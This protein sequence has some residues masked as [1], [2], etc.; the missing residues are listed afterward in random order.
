MVKLS[1][2]AQ[3]IKGSPIRKM[4]NMAN[5]M[6]DVVS[7]AL[8]EPDF[9]T[10][11]NIINAACEA[12]QRGETHY[13]PNAGILPL[14]QV[15]A[16]RLKSKNNVNVNPESEIIVTGGG[17]EAL[18][19]CMMVTIDSGD[20]VIVSNPYWS[21]HPSQVRMCGGIPRFVNVYEEDGFVYNPD[22]LRKAINKNT[23]AI[24]I[25]SPANPTGGVVERDTLEE[26]A[27]IAKEY[28]LLIISDEVYQYFVYD[29]AEFVSIASLEG[30]KE[31]TI[32]VDSFSKSYAMTG[33]RIGY[34][35]GCEEIIQNMIKLQEN[36]I[37]CVNS[38][39]Q[40][41]AIEALEG[42]QEHLEYMINK[43]QQRRELIVDG[44]NDIEGLSCISPKGAFYVFV[45]IFKTGMTSEEF[46]IELLKNAR[47]VVVPGSG[48]G[49]A[50]EGFVRISYA[51]SEENIVEG[52]RRMNDFME[53]LNKR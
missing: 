21:N 22:N 43:Y 17:M 31:R 24:L 25:N 6:D 29:G 5:A 26:I 23:K 28:N 50:G 44:I 37:S 9:T 20:E 13:T 19:L 10:S 3:N 33:W 15:I 4:F 2:I 34:G 32:V 40:Y 14:R 1:N 49:E 51:T 47:V 18:M 16:K 46:A 42:T 39:T 45:N 41:A 36:V 48:F 30:M 8:G 12:L 11:G 7:F 27:E 53:E 35:A 38:S 52:L